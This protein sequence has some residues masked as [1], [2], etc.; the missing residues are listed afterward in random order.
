MMSLANNNYNNTNSNAL[1]LL[2]VQKTIGGIVGRQ[3]NFKCCYESF[4]YSKTSMTRAITSH[5]YENT[6]IQTY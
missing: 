2:S 3:N 6:P 4:Q 1:R 5:H